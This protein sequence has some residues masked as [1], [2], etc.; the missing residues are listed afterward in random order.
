L[1]YF[2]A[3][4]RAEWPIVKTAPDIKNTLL[5]KVIKVRQDQSTK[6]K[7]DDDDG[8]DGVGG[9]GG[10]TTFMLA[11]TYRLPEVSPVDMLSCRLRFSAKSF[12]YAVKY[13]PFLQT[14]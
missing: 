7:R 13:L 4:S 2:R 1:I 10:D 9:D 11:A 3:D 5:W 12:G 14:R 8:Y 6:Q